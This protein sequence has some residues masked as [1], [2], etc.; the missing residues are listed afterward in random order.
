LP[1]VRRLGHRNLGV[2]VVSQDDALAL[3]TARFSTVD[4]SRHRLVCAWCDADWT[5]RFRF[6]AAGPEVLRGDRPENRYPA[7]TGL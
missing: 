6:P 1:I 4:L 2:Y 7:A 5:C 3:S